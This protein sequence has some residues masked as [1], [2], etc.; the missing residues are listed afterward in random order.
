MMISYELWLFVLY[1]FIRANIRSLHRIIRA[2]RVCRTPSQREEV[3]HISDRS[4]LR[5]VL[6]EA[7]VFD[8]KTGGKI[9]GYRNS[10]IRLM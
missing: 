1:F 2:S 3:Y 10:F 7:S 8:E 4:Q 9:H 6:E 5:I